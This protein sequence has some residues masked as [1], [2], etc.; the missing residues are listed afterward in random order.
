MICNSKKPLKIVTSFTWKKEKKILIN[1]LDFL[2]ETDESNLDLIYQGMDLISHFFPLPPERNLIPIVWSAGAVAWS[3]RASIV[4]SV[5]GWSTTAATVTGVSADHR[6][7]HRTSTSGSHLR[8]C[9]VIPCSEAAA[10][11]ST[12]VVAA[13]GSALAAGEG[14]DFLCVRREPLRKFLLCF[15]DQLNKV[16][17]EVTILVVEER[18]GK[19]CKYQNKQLN[20]VPTQL[21]EI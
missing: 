10:E 19:T 20:N 16:P 11:A 2:F 18:G 21:N 8:G 17:D 5:I 9:T 1:N 6:S 4:T 7:T 13:A 12:F 3:V 14:V 15:S